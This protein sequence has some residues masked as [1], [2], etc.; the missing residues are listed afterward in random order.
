MLD[1]TA[2]QSNW[3][4]P[5]GYAMALVGEFAERAKDTADVDALAAPVEATTRDLGFRYHALVHHADL[6]RRPPRFLFVQNYPAGWVEAFT[7]EAEIV[8]SEPAPP[9]SAPVSPPPQQSSRS[10]DVSAALPKV[11]P[12]MLVLLGT[13]CDAQM[14]KVV[15]RSQQVKRSCGCGWLRNRAEA[16]ALA[17]KR[18]IRLSRTLDCAPAVATVTGKA[19]SC[20]AKE[21]RFHEPG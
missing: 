16:S 20:L 15:S 1:S 8:M 4:V 9:A 21:L 14:N 11:D 12:E 17:A 3:T 10:P 18:V 13:D 7:A 5:S 19:G 2:P 6:A